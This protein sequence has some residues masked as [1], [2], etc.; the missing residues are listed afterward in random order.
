[1]SFLDDLADLMPYTVIATPVTD[2]GVGDLV[3]G[4][5]VNL[6]Q[7]F[8]DDEHRVMKDN[9]GREIVSTGQIIFGGNTPDLNE[10]DFRFTLPSVFSGPRTKLTAAKVSKVSDE[11]SGT[12]GPL[13]QIID[14]R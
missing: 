3:D 1:V 7:C 5:P 9:K 8:I 4:T 13:Y 6:T 10:T 2:N 12:N 14:L 11:D